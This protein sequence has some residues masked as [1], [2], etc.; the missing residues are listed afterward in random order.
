LVVETAGRRWEGIG[1]I[2]SLLLSHPLFY[3]AMVVALAG[4][5]LGRSIQTATVALVLLTTVAATIGVAG[6]LGTRCS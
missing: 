2:G 5:P 3:F 6:L 1:A 4:W